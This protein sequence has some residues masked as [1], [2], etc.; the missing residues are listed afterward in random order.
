MR[1]TLVIIDE[2]PRIAGKTGAAMVRG[3]RSRAMWLTFAATT[4]RPA[5]LRV[6]PVSLSVHCVK[7][8]LKGFEISS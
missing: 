7:I 1:K 5:A 6:I 8:Y 2:D 3:I 4:K